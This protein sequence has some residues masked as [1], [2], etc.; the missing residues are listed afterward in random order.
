MSRQNESSPADINL[1]D[2]SQLCEAIQTLSTDRRTH[3][4][5]TLSHIIPIDPSLE[6]PSLL[7]FNILEIPLPNSS[8]PPSASDDT[9]SSALGY[10]ALLTSTLAAY[11]S[12]PL[13]YPIS[14]MGSRSTVIDLISVMS[15]PR[16]FPLYSKGVERYRFDYGVFLLNKDIEQVRTTALSA[17][18][19]EADSTR[20]R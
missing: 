19:E 8:Y 1:L 9:L 3:L 6:S 7:L 12:L 17:Q 18:C 11:L 10:A 14:C 20:R 2:H 15:G 16:A 5:T 4:I 13:H